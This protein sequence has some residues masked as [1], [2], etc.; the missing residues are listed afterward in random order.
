MMPNPKTLLH[1]QIYIIP[2][3]KTTNNKTLAS[4]SARSLHLYLFILHTTL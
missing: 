4:S 3:D 2:S 1:Q